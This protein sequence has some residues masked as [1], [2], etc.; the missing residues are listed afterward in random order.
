M[1]AVSGTSLALHPGVSVI[2]SAHTT[3][4]KNVMSR[5]VGMA[6]GVLI[7]VLFFAAVGARFSRPVTAAPGNHTVTTR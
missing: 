2:P 5:T 3:R 7:F 6:I 1:R 4:G